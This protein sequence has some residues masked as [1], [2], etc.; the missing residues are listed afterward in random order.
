MRHLLS[1]KSALLNGMSITAINMKSATTGL[2]EGMGMKIGGESDP[3]AMQRKNWEQFAEEVGI[4]PRLVM[5]RVAD[6]AKRIQVSRLRAL[7]GRVCRVQMRCL[8]P[9][10][11]I[12]RRAA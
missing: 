9:L 3:G 11:A 8:V 6:I 2:A 5:T 10:D 4:K 12:D 1:G 7:H